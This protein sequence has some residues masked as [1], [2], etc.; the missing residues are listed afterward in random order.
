MTRKE[1]PA[2][3]CAGVKFSRR[4]ASAYLPVEQVLEIIFTL[5][6]VN[7]DPLEE[8]AP[9]APLGLEDPL[10]L[11]GLEDD[12]LLSVPRIRT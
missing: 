9:L 12:P 11:L 10:A 7:D 5:L 1:S 8:P 4:R 3:V 2:L 6:T